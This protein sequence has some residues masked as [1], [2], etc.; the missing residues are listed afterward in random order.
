MAVK[1]VG[2]YHLPAL[3]IL[4]RASDVTG[5]METCSWKTL[6]LT[7]CVHIVHL[8][9]YIWF[10]EFSQLFK[11]VPAKNQECPTSSFV[12][13]DLSLALLSW[14]SYWNCYRSIPFLLI[15]FLCLNF[16]LVEEVELD[17]SER[18]WSRGKVG[19]ALPLSQS[20]T[21]RRRSYETSPQGR[22]KRVET[23]FG[24]IGYETSTRTLVVAVFHF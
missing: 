9:I 22:G 11:W 15:L 8:N 3:S 21:I 23:C 10:C 20:P 5:S 13:R 16:L 7:Q 1:A 24:Q 17:G 18:C 19:C 14:F 6:L 2:V 4:L 12:G